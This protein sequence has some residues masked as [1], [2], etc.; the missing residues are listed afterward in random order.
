MSRCAESGA[1]MT[2]PAIAK[3]I[4]VPFTAAATALAVDQACKMIAVAVL[5]HPD[6]R[7]IPITSFFNLTLAYNSGISFGLFR[8]HLSEASSA[9][10]ILSVC[11]AAA[12]LWWGA[13]C[14]RKSDQAAF[15]MISGGAV[16]NA[17][18]RLR[19]GAVTDFL[20]FHV[21][22]WHWPAFN[23]ADVAIFVGAALIVVRALVPESGLDPTSVGNK[24]T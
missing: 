10:A 7:N 16:G 24:D 4:G 11:V 13:H 18:D 3:R 21:G 22:G 14:R 1:G 17:F 19:Q 6:P 23:L 9:F 20:D 2:F 12:L 5:M 8:D 15:G